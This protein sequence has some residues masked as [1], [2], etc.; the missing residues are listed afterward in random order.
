[1]TDDAGREPRETHR[2]DVQESVGRALRQLDG[3][4]AGS[5]SLLTG[6]S[7]ADLDDLGGFADR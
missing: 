1:M 5:V 3:T 4:V 6:M 2:A 7:R